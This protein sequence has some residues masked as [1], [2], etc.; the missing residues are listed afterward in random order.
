MCKPKE[1]GGIGFRDLESFNKALLAKQCWRIIKNPNALWVKILKARYFPNCSFLEA[2]KGSRASWGWSSLLAGRNT[3]DTNARWQINNG[4]KVDVWKDRWIPNSKRGMIEPVITNNRF[5]PLQV[6]ELIDE[7]S[8][9]WR[10]DHILP[11]ISDKDAKSI[12]A[13]PLE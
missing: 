4:R 10:I 3:I 5:T 1:V 9:S 2:S 13:I 8:R 6:C 11:F 12:T 7:D